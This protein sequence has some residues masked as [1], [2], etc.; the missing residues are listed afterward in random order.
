MSF[1]FLKL[2][3]EWEV[4]ATDAARQSVGLLAIWNP[5]TYNLN[6]YQTEAG[7]LLVGKIQGFKDFIRILNIYAP[8]KERKDFWDI[9]DASGVLSLQNLVV[10]G[11]LNFTMFSSKN[12]GM[13]NSLDP[14]DGYSQ[15]LFS[16]Y[17]LV[18]IKP[19]KLLPTWKNKRTR[20]DGTKKRIDRFLWH[21]LLGESVRYRSW[22]MNSNLSDHIL[23]SLQ[24]EGDTT[25]TNFPFKFNQDW[26]KD[27][28]FYSMVRDV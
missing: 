16:K 19:S 3:N 21:Y 6:P 8:C 17:N 1:F 5:K 26:L 24:L 20:K 4:C 11:D 10:A 2:L 14:L 15:S 13:A 18:D 12:W 28:S 22:N 23:I 25:V 9:I 7:I 27:P